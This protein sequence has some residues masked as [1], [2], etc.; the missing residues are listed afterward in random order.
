MVQLACG[1]RGGGGEGRG[2]GGGSGEAKGS[3]AGRA[4]QPAA[5]QALAAQAALQTG[6]APCLQ[7]RPGRPPEAASMR[8]RNSGDGFIGRDL[9][10]GW[11]CV[12]GGVC[13]GWGGGRVSRPTGEPAVQ[14]HARKAC[15]QTQRRA[16]NAHPLLPPASPTPCTLP[17]P[18]RP[19]LFPPPPP[20]PP[21]PPTH[22]HL[23]RHEKRVVCQLH[24]LH[25]RSRVV[26][27]HKAQ[28]RGLKGAN[29]L[30]VDL[31]PAR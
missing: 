9:N 5:V 27:A 21:P 28:P 16:S 22:P 18:P 3:C 4:W 11:N 14:P 2:S 31:V 10:S 30:R 1:Q 25:A 24:N 26:L 7:P 23:R 19:A 17:P 12:C 15:L 13:G 29:Q 20:P 6:A 8:P